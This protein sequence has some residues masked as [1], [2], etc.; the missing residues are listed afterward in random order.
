MK[1]TTSTQNEPVGHL[2]SNPLLIVVQ[3]IWSHEV[4]YEEIDSFSE[5]ERYFMVFNHDQDR[6]K[7][8]SILRFR[9]EKLAE[10]IG[11]TSTDNTQTTASAY[12]SLMD[13]LSWLVSW[14]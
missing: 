7:R 5:R 12:I 11:L 14:I 9:T 13:N 10:T 1:D 8:T 3:D 2:Q 6:G 4:E